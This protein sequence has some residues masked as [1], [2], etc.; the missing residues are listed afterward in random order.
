MIS[1]ALRATARLLL[2]QWLAVLSAVLYGI[3]NDQITLTI[4]PEYFTVFKRQQFGPLLQAFGLEHAPV[5]V[6][7]LVV[8]TAATWWFGC[9]LGMILGVVSTAGRAPRAS[10][11][12]YLKAIG[13]VMLVTAQM[14]L[15]CGL[16]AYGAEPLAQPNSERWPFLTGIL[17]IRPAFAVGWWHNGAYAG[18]LL[19]TLFACRRVHNMRLTTPAASVARR[20]P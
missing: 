7:A 15:L 16:I 2:W 9:F 1:E 5:R 13:W 14:S 17:D 12:V 18:A 19:G 4:S 6:E 8:G 10:T 20:S 3:L 11:K